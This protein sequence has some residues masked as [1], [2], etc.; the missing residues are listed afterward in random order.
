MSVIID[1]MEKAL[2]SFQNELK[3]IRSGRAHPSVL[4]GVKVEAYDQFMPI[5][6]VANVSTPDPKTIL[7]QPWDKGLTQAI[8]KAIVKSDLGFNPISD[9]NVLR[10]I[11][12]ALTEERREELKK[13]VRHRG[14][15]SK[16]AMRNVR[17]DENE[18]IKNKQKEKAFSEDEAKKELDKIQKLTDDYIR[19]VDT[20]ILA[21]E[22][23]L[24]EI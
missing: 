13:N 19:K 2:V 5:N 18:V 3:T 12:P 16:V 7:V 15:E 24:S 21:K 20:M 6:Q 11:V 23:E 17:R 4:D 22:K 10:I 14:E 1:R 8:E 9:G